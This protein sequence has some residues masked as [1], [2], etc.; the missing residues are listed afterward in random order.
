MKIRIGTRKSPLALKQAEFIRRALQAA[1]PGVAVELVHITT[2]GDRFID[3]PLADI[4]GK[5]LFTKEIEEAL[6]GGA[7]DI[8]VHSV[9]DMETRLPEGLMI[10]CCPEREDA[11]DVLIGAASFSA[12]PK[13]AAFGTASLR[14][15]AQALMKRPDFKIV[16]LR[17]NVET[18]LKKVEQ[19]EIAATLLAV[20]GL[21]RLG[22][23]LPPSV[24][25]VSEF[26]PAAGQG[27]IA[28]ECREKD[29]RIRDLLAPLSHSATESAIACERAFLAAL[30]G[31]CRTP[32]AGHAVIQ[33]RMLHFEG[34]L[35]EPDGNRHWRITAQG[36]MADAERLGQAA[37]KELRAKKN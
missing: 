6:L 32:I 9:K 13:G 19:G 15:G 34:L 27:A 17:G 10:G 4:G 21:K 29:A 8:A 7:I 37:G 33:N 25:P 26:L 16:P 30:D 20:A 1:H 14:R 24:L 28:V 36:D 3:R 31:S 22:L 2:S 12:I 23:A 35:A 5:G 18:R 11:R